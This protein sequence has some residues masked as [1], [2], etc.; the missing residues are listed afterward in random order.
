MTGAAGSARQVRQDQLLL[1]CRRQCSAS[2][3]EPVPYWLRASVDAEPVHNMYVVGHASHQVAG[4]H[5]LAS[6]PVIERQVNFVVA[7]LQRADVDLAMQRDEKPRADADVTLGNAL[8]TEP[9]SMR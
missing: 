9:A 2:I 4:S 3:R 1:V 7:R 6:P 5:A 8:A